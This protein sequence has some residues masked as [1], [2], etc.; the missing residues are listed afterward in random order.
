[1]AIGTMIHN[2]EGSDSEIISVKKLELASYEVAVA[3]F[4]LEISK[5]TRL[6]EPEDHEEFSFHAN[7]LLRILDAKRRT[8]ERMQLV[9]KRA[10]LT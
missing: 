9:T 3:K 7:E 6:I 2:A 1:M 8:T 5:E 4:W 10:T